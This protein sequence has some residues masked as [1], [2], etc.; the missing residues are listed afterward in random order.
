MNRPPIFVGGAGRSGTT[1][2][3]VILDSHPNIACG[4]ELKVIPSVCRL[5]YELQT[6]FRMPL[7]EYHLKPKQVNAIFGQ[8]ILSL[9]ENYRAQAGKPRIAEKS[10][11]NVFFFE[12]LHYLFPE[13][14]LLHLIR[15]G[16]DVVSSLLRM[17]WRN[18]KT[19]E[20]LEYTQDAR[21]AAEYW[22]NAVR[23]GQMARQRPSLAAR[24]LEVRYEDLVAKPE[25]TLKRVCDFIGEPWDPAVLKFH[26]KER[27]L[28]GESSAEQVQKEIYQSAV[29]RWRKDLSPE[30]RQAVKEAAGDLLMV[31]GYAQDREW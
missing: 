25:E 15:D 8:M 22:A 21:K 18:P 20:R 6:A 10:P 24:Y 26:E 23:A 30:D 17:D 14:P 2:M 27:N 19:G 16:R 1:L 29:A 31:L 12:H 13:S 5:W 9:L 4:P 11:N 3:R 28:A 7:R